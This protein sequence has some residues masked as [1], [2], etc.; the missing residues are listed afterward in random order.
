MCESSFANTTAEFQWVAAGV[1]TELR[2]IIVTLEAKFNMLAVDRSFKLVEHAMNEKMVPLDT[3]AQALEVEHAAKLEAL[4]ELKAKVDA[5]SAKAA[6]KKEARALAKES[7]LAA[8]S[9]KSSESTWE[10]ASEP[11][12]IELTTLGTTIALVVGMVV[13]NLAHGRKGVVAGGGSGSGSG[14]I[15]GY[16]VEQRQAGETVSLTSSSPTSTQY[17][18]FQ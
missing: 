12:R 6:A 3:Q 7:L 5:N 1:M 13:A 18:A 2:A 14:K 16:A 10:K 4:L 11:L 8:K 9:S 17:G 15:G